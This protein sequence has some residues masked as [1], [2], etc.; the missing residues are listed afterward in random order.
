MMIVG[1]DTG[2][3][4]LPVV[5]N[6]ET[7]VDVRWEVTLEVVPSVVDGGCRVGWLDPE[8]DGCVMDEIVT[9]P[10][11]SPIVFMKSAVVLTFLPALS[12]VCSLAVLAGGG[13]V[14]AAAA[15]LAVVESV[16]A[17]VCVQLD[18]ERV[19]VQPDVGSELPTVYE[20]GNGALDVV[21][22][23]VGQS[24][25]RMDSEDTLPALQD[26]R[27]VMSFLV[28]P[29]AV[30]I[31]QFFYRMM[32]VVMTGSHRMLLVGLWSV[33]WTWILCGWY[34]GKIAGLLR[35]GLMLKS[36]SGG[37]CCVVWHECRVCQSFRIRPV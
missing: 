33:T 9:A 25:L 2:P 7:Q 20:V 19:C 6:T 26:E 11:M 30:L 36:L 18:I 13:G 37:E 23:R 24:C 27:S 21:G 14:R 28:R 15:P 32:N 22:L 8:S 17:R 29:A 10:D 16:T 5:A 35:L 12:E 31:S 34:I 1:S 4:A 3:L